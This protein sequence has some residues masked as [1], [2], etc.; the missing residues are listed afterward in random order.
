ME[1]FLSLVER[2]NE[3]Y[4]DHKK[5]KECKVVND[6]STSGV[7]LRC[8]NSNNLTECRDFNLYNVVQV[9]ETTNEQNRGNV[10]IKQYKLT[11][12]TFKL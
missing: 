12:Y 8:L 5:L 2:K 9:R 1:Y 11:P 3:F 7:I 4:I 10:I 6:I